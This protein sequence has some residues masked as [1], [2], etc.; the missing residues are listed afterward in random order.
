M[1]KAKKKGVK[2]RNGPRRVRRIAR[3]PG[4]MRAPPPVGRKTP[5]TGPTARRSAGSVQQYISLLVDPCSSDLVH[6]PYGGTKGAAVNRFEAT[7]S[8]P[9]YSAT[10]C[11]G[12][13]FH[14]VWGFYNW[15]ETSGGN[16]IT[17]TSVWVGANTPALSGYYNPITTNPGSPSFTTGFVGTNC[18]TARGAAAC[19]ELSSLNTVFNTGGR[20]WSGVVSGAQLSPGF[21]AYGVTPTY[22]LSADVIPLLTNLCRMPAE[23]KCTLNW[24]PSKADERYL[25]PYYPMNNVNYGGVNG[26]SN[27][28]EVADDFNG[29]NFCVFVVQLPATGVNQVSIRAT[30]VLEYTLSPGSGV[31]S[32]SASIANTGYEVAIRALQSKDPNWYVDTFKK[33]GSLVS[34]TVKSFAS[35]GVFGAGAYLAG[36]VASMLL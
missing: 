11:I 36:R 18:A 35:G 5:A 10:N 13:A 24:V 6:P 9:V 31:V 17:T 7:V 32:N 28:P 12:V 14:P 8:G 1:A 30:N 22:T 26:G 20:V 4:P 21:P 23:G 2:G 29:S 27:F 34:G 3:M 19:L 15:A 25:Q 33:V 16:T